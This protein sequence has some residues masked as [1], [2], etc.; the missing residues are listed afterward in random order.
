[1]LLAASSFALIGFPLDD[2]WHRL[3]GQDVTL[4]GPTH[5][6]MIGGAALAFV[7]QV[8]LLG[9]ARMSE[10]EPRTGSARAALVAS[11]AHKLRMPALFGG[12][13]IGLSTFQ[14]E[15]DFGVPQFRMMFEPVL[16]AFAAS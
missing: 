3:F 4:W 10:R 11:V 7:G 13:L 1:G 12:F 9:E 2:F 15:F 14:A 6:M 5:L 8:T 16:I